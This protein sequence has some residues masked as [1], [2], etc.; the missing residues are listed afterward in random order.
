MLSPAVVPGELLT[1]LATMAFVVL[2][3]L[4]LVVMVAVV[5]AALGSRLL[6][7]V[8]LVVALVLSIEVV[9]PGDVEVALVMRRLPAVVVGVVLL[10]VAAMV[11]MVEV[12][13]ERLTEPMLA[14]VVALAARATCVVLV[15]LG[16]QIGR[17]HV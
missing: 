5:V 11:T 13:N 2:A 1:V 17:A 16:K 6:L 10:T 12:V 4:R 15:V 9:R 14:V 8:V 3:L 7:L